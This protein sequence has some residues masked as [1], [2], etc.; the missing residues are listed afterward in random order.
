L[1]RGVETVV[2]AP[3]FFLRR[4]HGTETVLVL[5]DEKSVRSLIRRILSG[6]GY[7]VLDTEDS[8]EAIRL[9]N[10]HA[11]K[12]DLFITDVVLPAMSGPQVAQR[13]SVLR[14]DMKILYI[15]GYPGRDLVRH[16]LS[17]G[18][19]DQ[20]DTGFLEKPFTPEAL[21]LRVRQ[22]LDAR[23]VEEEDAKTIEEEDA[24]AVEEESVEPS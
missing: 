9:C 23:T 13:L 7:Q 21:A 24:S 10:R 12:I 4:S 6:E 5:E 3:P 16:G 17:D 2:E 11:G 1:Q 19:S 14:P 18:A 20:E 22:V 15:S 8:G